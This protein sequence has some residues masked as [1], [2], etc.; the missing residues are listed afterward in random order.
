[1][2]FGGPWNGSGGHF[3]KNVTLAHPILAAAKKWPIRFFDPEQKFFGC[4]GTHFWDWCVPGTSDPKFDAGFG[5]FGQFYIL[6]MCRNPIQKLEVPEPENRA[7][8]PGTAI[9]PDPFIS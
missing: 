9:F 3:G 1:M 5:L 2:D 8:V 4:S 7:F 6:D